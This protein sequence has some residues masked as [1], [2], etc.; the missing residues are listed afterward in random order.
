MGGFRVAEAGL[1]HHISF[2]CPQKQ[3]ETV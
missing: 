3:Q 2:S 1:G